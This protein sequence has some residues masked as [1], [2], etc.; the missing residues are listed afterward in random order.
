MKRGLDWGG[1]ESGIFAV[2]SDCIMFRNLI[3]LNCYKFY[4][5]NCA[6]TSA[7]VS[8]VQPRNTL[9]QSLLSYFI[10]LTKGNL[11]N[12]FILTPVSEQDLC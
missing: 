5:K 8:L 10:I 4:F 9:L 1:E 12:C 6:C 11:C 2:K 3:F 7:P